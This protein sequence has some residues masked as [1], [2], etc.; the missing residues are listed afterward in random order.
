[1]RTIQISDEV[2]NFIDSKAVGLDMNTE[3]KVL[4]KLL[5]IKPSTSEDNAKRII[6]K[7]KFPKKM[8]EKDKSKGMYW[9]GVKFWEGMQLRF[10]GRPNDRAIVK[11]GSIVYGGSE[12][13]SPSQAAVVAN[14]GTSTNGWIHWEYL[15]PT[16]GTWRVLDSLREKI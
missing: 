7:I 1:M 4:R 16:T 13:K 12:Y 10:K 14:S 9:K 15:D 6:P 5:G 3:D 11:N 8:D 2:W